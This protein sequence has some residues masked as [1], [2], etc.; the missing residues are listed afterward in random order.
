M[1]VILFFEEFRTKKTN[2][3]RLNSKNLALE[4]SYWSDF[5]TGTIET[6]LHVCIQ[7]KKFDQKQ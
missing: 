5:S 1:T 7:R 3:N 4:R 2:K 6:E